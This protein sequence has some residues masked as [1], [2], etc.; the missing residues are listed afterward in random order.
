[1]QRL[2]LCL[3]CALALWGCTP[4][5]PRV[6][7][8]AQM[9]M[10]LQGALTYEQ[11][12]AHFGIPA[13]CEATGAT[14]VCEWRRGSASQVSYVVGD[15]RFTDTVPPSRAILFFTDDRLTMFQLK[16]PWD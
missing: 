1:M 4:A 11:A 16:G 8:T 14:R 12:L 9:L 5:T 13:R 15:V 3:T 7:Q 10:D 2:V 6:T